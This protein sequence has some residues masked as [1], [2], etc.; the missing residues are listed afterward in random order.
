MPVLRTVQLLYLKGFESAAA[1]HTETFTD[2]VIKAHQ[3]ASFHSLR[4]IFGYNPEQYLQVLIVFA[5]WNVSFFF[6][7]NG[8]KHQLINENEC[9]QGV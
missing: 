8:M 9:Q 4:S 3:P 7:H 2:C 1:D 6:L 5:R